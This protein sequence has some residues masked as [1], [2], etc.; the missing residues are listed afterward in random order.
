MKK[1]YNK[2]SLEEAKHCLWVDEEGMELTAILW[3]FWAQERGYVAENSMTN[4]VG[5]FII[6]DPGRSKTIKVLKRV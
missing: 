6:Y 5:S 2:V 4:T 1:R 3:K